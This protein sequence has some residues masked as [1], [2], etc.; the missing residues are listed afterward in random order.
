M[1]FRLRKP[2]EQD[3]TRIRD[4]CRDLPL[5]YPE[6]GCSRDGEPAGY[7]VDNY[8]VQLGSGAATF[9]RARAALRAWRM[10]QLGWV[11][12]CWPD[13]EVKEG[14]LVGTLARVFGLW[15]VNVCRIVFVVD[16]K[17]PVTRY[18]LAY[19]TLAGHAEIGEERFLVQWHLADDSVWYD[20][21]AVSKPG[22]FLTRLAYPLTRR[23]QRRFGRDSLRAMVDA[24]RQP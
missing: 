20:I 19:G 1:M 11:E 10:L 21:R 3:L 16:E 4:R 23:L 24:A 12:P 13:T 5:S 22:G 18:G 6:V 7:V 15:A 14:I 9:E 2:H 8:R 17:G